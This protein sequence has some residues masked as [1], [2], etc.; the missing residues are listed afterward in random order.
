MGYSD[1]VWVC[2]YPQVASP[3]LQQAYPTP[4]AELGFFSLALP[5]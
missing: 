1:P 2:D 4:V 3:G 5:Y